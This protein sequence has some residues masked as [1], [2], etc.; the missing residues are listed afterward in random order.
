MELILGLAFVV[1]ASVVLIYLAFDSV[2]ERPAV[3]LAI[4]GLLL[5]GALYGLEVFLRI[6]FAY[7]PIT[8]QPVHIHSEAPILPLLGILLLVAGGAGVVALG[9]A[10]M[11]LRKVWVEVPAAGPFMPLVLLPPVALLIYQQ[12]EAAAER[13]APVTRAY[14]ASASELARQKKQNMEEW[15]KQ[16]HRL[17]EVWAMQ[18]W[19]VNNDDC[20]PGHPGFMDEPAFVAGCRDH[21]TELRRGNGQEWA[22]S[23]SIFRAA[24]CT[25]SLPGVMHDPDFAAGCESAVQV[26]RQPENARAAGRTWAFI[27]K[28]DY[29]A[30]CPRTRPDAPPEFAAGC[31][32]EVHRWRRKI[33]QEW[34]QSHSPKKEAACEANDK[35]PFQRWVDAD[36]IEGCRQEVVASRAR[37]SD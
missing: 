5:S 23:R 14:E 22:R 30:D 1:V 25:S 15:K 8:G 18:Y 17:G 12:Y 24:D 6:G 10:L 29:V 35:G 9:L 26:E 27:N 32:E 2:E 33:G 13:A 4:T 37:K 31:E 36:F 34:A 7:D 11:L 19:I 28:I 3:T 21:A 20:R 16:Q